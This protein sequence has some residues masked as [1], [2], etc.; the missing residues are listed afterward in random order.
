MRSMGLALAAALAASP[1]AALDV[2]IAPGDVLVLNPTNPGRGYGDVVLHAAGV[3]TAERCRLTALRVE[4][5]AAGRVRLT[6][7]LPVETVLADTRDLAAQPVPAQA[8][9]QLLDAHGP[10][11]LFGAPTAYATSADLAPG[12]AAFT[13]RRHYSVGFRPDQARVSATCG[14]KT[15]RASV[16]IKAHASPIAY[17]FPLQGAWLMQSAASIDSHHRLNAAGEFASDFFKVDADGRAYKGDR[18]DPAAW[19]GWGQPVLA[20]ADGVVTRVISGEVQDR[21]AFLPRPGETPQQ[22]GQRLEAAGLARARADFAAAAAGNLIVVRHEAGGAVEYSA[23][24]HLKP[25][26]VAVEVGDKVTAGQK[27]AEVGDTGDSPA[28]HLHF[29]V[30]VGPD[31]FFTRS[32]PFSFQ[33]ARPVTGPELGRIVA[34]R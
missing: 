25:G 4:L 16:A 9:A 19:F 20:A 11:G 32:L 14:G 3:R 24:G 22:T 15:A 23:Y 1:A 13:V 28:V 17:R 26:S 7:D 34:P 18:I 31:P 29:Q 33:D 10:A 21:R 8:N 12:E 27:I 2:R 30:N 6:E 5:L